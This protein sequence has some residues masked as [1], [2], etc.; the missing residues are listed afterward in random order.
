[1]SASAGRR[2][3][4]RR[5][6]HAVIEYLVISA[7]FVAAIILAKDTVRDATSNMLNQA[8]DQIPSSLPQ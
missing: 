4:E 8:I 5:R 2:R 6:G 3:G 7:A 1:M